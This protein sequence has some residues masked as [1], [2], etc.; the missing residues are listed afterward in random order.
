MCFQLDMSV[1]RKGS[2][3]GEKCVG[4]RVASWLSLVAAKPSAAKDWQLVRA[5][6]ESE[7]DGSLIWASLSL[8]A[9]K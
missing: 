7:M 6:I 1:S 3:F 4:M 5:R 2:P 9:T 8:K